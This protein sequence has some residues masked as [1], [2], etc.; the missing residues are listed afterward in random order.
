MAAGSAVGTS[1]CRPRA[2]SKPTLMPRKQASSTILVKNVRKT[3]V[4][5]KKRIAAS[6][7]NRIRKLTR[8]RFQYDRR[9]DFFRAAARQPTTRS[10]VLNG[11]RAKAGS[12]TFRTRAIWRAA[13]VVD[14]RRLGR[15]RC[16]QSCASH[17]RQP[18]HSVK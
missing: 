15:G 8:K 12:E 17:V 10:A 5:P 4:L 6:S 18:K 7:K 11:D 3:T 13:L 1:S 2:A 14:V 16:S 9:I